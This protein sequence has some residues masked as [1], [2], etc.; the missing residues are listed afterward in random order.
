MQLKVSALPTSNRLSFAATDRP[1]KVVR[2]SYL[3]LGRGCL[4]NRSPTSDMDEGC[5]G[6]ASAQRRSC[7]WTRESTKSSSDHSRSLLFSS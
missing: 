1:E 5:E 2:Q 4:V 6:L 3:R 7:K